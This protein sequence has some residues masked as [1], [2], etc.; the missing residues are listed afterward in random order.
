MH[1]VHSAHRHQRTTMFDFNFTGLHS[2]FREAIQRHEPSVAFT[3][4]NGRGRFLFLIFIPTD[5]KG[6]IKWSA[7]ELFIILGRTQGV[8]RFDLKGQHY[9]VGEFKIRMTEKDVE[10]IR[11]ELGLDDGAIHHGTPFVIDAFL[12]DLNAAMPLTVSLEDKVAGIQ[13]Q[14]TLVKTHCAKYVDDA[15]KIHLLG[16]RPLNKPRKPREETLRKLYYLKADPKAIA[17]LVR[18]LKALN[19]T[20]AW[21]DS[22]PS[23][24]E[25]QFDRLWTST[26]TALRTR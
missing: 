22:E 25:A 20:V 12:A 16:P 24:A 6:D 21:T 18:N 3:L 7:I 26:A 11:T 15:L 4:V 1:A 5:S 19:W 9:H 23:N 10:A 13:E 17:S 14:L 2:V 8:L